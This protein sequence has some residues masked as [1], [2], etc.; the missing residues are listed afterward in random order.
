MRYL[1]LLLIV[2]L[3]FDLYAQSCSDFENL[4]KQGD[5]NWIN[6]PSPNYQEAIRAYT[7]A[8]F[9]CTNRAAEAQ[10]KIQS[11][12]AEI[13]GLKRKAEEGERK[14]R[15]A[16]AAALAAQ[17]KEKEAFEKEKEAKIKAEQETQNAINAK[18]AELKQLQRSFEGIVKLFSTKA[19]EVV[20][21]EKKRQFF[22]SAFRL[23]RDSLEGKFS[24]TS[25]L[26]EASNAVLQHDKN[27]PE[28]STEFAYCSINDI[29]I[30]ED[31]NQ[32]YLTGGRN[33]ILKTTLSPSDAINPPVLLEKKIIRGEKS[34]EKINALAVSPDGVHQAIA[35]ES[36]NISIFN[37][38]NYL[39]D[40]S[41]SI[42]GSIIYDLTFL[43]NDEIA[44]VGA[45]NTFTVYNI[46][47]DSVVSEFK[48]DAKPFKIIDY[49]INNLGAVFI[50][51]ENAVIFKS[52][53]SNLKLETSLL[54]FTWDH[55][56]RLLY[57][58]T[59]DNRLRIYNVN[60]LLGFTMLEE[61][62]ISPGLSAMNFH[63][64]G[65]LM[66]GYENGMIQIWDTKNILDLASA[67]IELKQRQAVASIHY[68]PAGNQIIC[69]G[70]Q[71]INFHPLSVDII[72]N[73]LE[74]NFS[75]Q[76]MS[77]DEAIYNKFISK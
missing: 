27:C 36:G 48:T 32:I 49:K 54:N 47:K 55:I 13:Q 50:G 26:I 29:F 9:D 75:V 25:Y 11:V 15:E 31:S 1:L 39:S 19:K 6:N 76:E 17:K 70:K 59:I 41:F 38:E 21:F 2:I 64:K 45:N 12:F 33:I 28:I 67:P 74:K 18:N 52:A 44:V 34:A 43:N 22:G 42:K 7:A 53:V 4:V 40:K 63:E 51:T 65:L 8:M 77:L 20:E 37:N 73:A 57:V 58:V 68:Y 56:N 62:T 23:N 5:N 71:S 46:I 35:G 3:N 72:Y 66:M 30:K 24:N 16:S 10:K 14:A 60:T 69:T 61:K